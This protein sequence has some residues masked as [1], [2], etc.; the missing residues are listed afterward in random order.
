MT[1]RKPPP[2]PVPAVSG[3]HR[4]EP[5]PEVVAPVDPA[6][7]VEFESLLSPVLN[8]AYGL[9]RRMTRNTADAEDLVQEA[10]LLAWRGFR[11]FRPGSN[12]R[13]WFFRILVNEFRSRY[14]KER[15]RGAEIELDDVTELYLYSETAG[16][17]I[18]FKTDDPGSALME[19][20]T[21]EHVEAAIA[22]LP[23]E[24]RMV[25]LLYFL[26]DY[27]YQEIADCLGVPVGTVRSRL[28]RSRRHMQRTLWRI[29]RDQGLVSALIR[30]PGEGD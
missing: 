29:A 24:Y 10:V 11:T 19:T 4:K 7:G 26:D 5:D 8:T 16:A 2:G 1:R 6:A 3:K 28:H 9:A 30:D 18:H 21:T 17:G 13:A 20:L 12:F 22:A 15:R 23:E 27:S 14:R 25:A